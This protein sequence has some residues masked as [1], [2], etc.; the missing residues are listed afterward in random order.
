M[1][2]SA[3]NLGKKNESLGASRRRFFGFRMMGALL[4]FH[5][6]IAPLIHHKKMNHHH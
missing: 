3:L 4:L 2:S 5:I 1:M 6:F